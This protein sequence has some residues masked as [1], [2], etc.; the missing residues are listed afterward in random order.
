MQI[1]TLILSRSRVRGSICFFIC[2][3]EKIHENFE[4]KILYYLQKRVWWAEGRLHLQTPCWW[5]FYV[6]GTFSMICL[7]F[8]NEKRNQK[9]SPQR[10]RRT[11]PRKECPQ[12]CNKFYLR[13]RKDVICSYVDTQHAAIVYILLVEGMATRSFSSF[14]LFSFSLARAHTRD[15]LTISIFVF[16]IKTRKEKRFPESITRS[17]TST[18]PL[19]NDV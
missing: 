8:P 11:R 15:D 9:I 1:R 4:N 2:P 13:R 3:V 18:S 12:I 17:K 7:C 14:N 6:Q 16:T 10:H 5:S 19:E